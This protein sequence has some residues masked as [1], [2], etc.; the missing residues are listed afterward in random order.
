[1]KLQGR[2]L[3]SP[4]ILS[5]TPLSSLAEFLRMQVFQLAE[6]AGTQ[7]SRRDARTGLAVFCAG[8]LA[9]TIWLYIV[10]FSWGWDTTP[11]LAIGR[12]YFHLPY[13]MWSV[14]HY[15]SP[16]YPIFMTLMGVHHLDTLTFFRFGTLFVGG[17]M[18]L[19]LFLMLRPFNLNAALGAALLFTVSFGNA[20]FSSEMMNHHFHAFLLLLVSV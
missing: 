20:V 16:G 9:Q 5:R 15:Y 18:P 10:P 19:L 1:M 3:G 12:M 6:F 8:M 11:N 13:E 7:I 4:Q 14:K 2:L 17:L